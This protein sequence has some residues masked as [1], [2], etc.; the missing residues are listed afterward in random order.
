MIQI[1]QEFDE[2]DCVVITEGEA[3]KYFYVTCEYNQQVFYFFHVP[4]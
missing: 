3:K 2:I 4:F 1:I